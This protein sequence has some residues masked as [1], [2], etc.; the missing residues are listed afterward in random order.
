MPRAVANGSADAGRRKH[1][2]L[3]EQL[4]EGQA[5]SNFPTENWI[6]LQNAWAAR[7]YVTLDEVT[8]ADQLS[9]STVTEWD[10]PYSTFMDPDRIEVAKKRRV[11]YHGRTYDILSGRLS[12]DTSGRSVVLQSLAK[13]G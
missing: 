8:K 3:I 11:V 4:V 12:D 2:L 13:A 9:A 7:D 5:G 6:K 1:Y 10:I